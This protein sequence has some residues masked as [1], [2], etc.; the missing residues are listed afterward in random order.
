MVGGLSPHTK[1]SEAHLG[2]LQL[3]F[4]VVFDWWA[5]T[6]SVFCLSERQLSALN[7]MRTEKWSLDYLHESS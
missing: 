7:K 1:Y 5:S 3:L 6:E 4:L 2:Q